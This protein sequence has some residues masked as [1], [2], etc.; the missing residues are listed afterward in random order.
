[1]PHMEVTFG[2]LQPYVGF[3][4]SFD[5][6]SC[7]RDSAKNLAIETTAG[8]RYLFTPKVALF[9]EYK[10]SYQFALEYSD[11]IAAKYGYVGT[12]TFDVP[13]HCFVIGVS[14]HFKKR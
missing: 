5:I 6:F 13:H 8:V 2:R 3:G 9:C 10:F 1:M 12:M 4:T 7:R 14:Y 11:F